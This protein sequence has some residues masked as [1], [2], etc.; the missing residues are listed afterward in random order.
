MHY[1]VT[2]MDMTK[3]MKPRLDF[4]DSFQQSFRPR[5]IFFVSLIQNTEWW[6]MCDQD[7]DLFRHISPSGVIIMPVILKSSLSVF[8]GIRGAKDFQAFYLNQIVVQEVGTFTY[9]LQYELSFKLLKGIVTW[10]GY[11]FWSYYFL[12]GFIR[13]SRAMSWLPAITIL[14]LK[15]NIFK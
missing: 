1:A 5:M 10:Q 2:F 15:G 12:V 11:F 14:C 7:V 4:F 13:S 3:N 6:P 8:Y 9:L